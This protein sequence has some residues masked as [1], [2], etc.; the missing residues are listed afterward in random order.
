MATQL[1]Q[2]AQRHR[3]P[4]REIRTVVVCL[5]GET[6]P[7]SLAELAATKLRMR[8]LTPAGVIPH[9]PTATTW[10]TRKLVDSWQGLTSGGPIKLLDLAS[11]RR[12]A[13]LA[14]AAQWRLW[15]QVVDGTRPAQPFWAF[16]DRHAADPNRYP[17]EQAQAEYQAQPRILAMNTHNALPGT[18]CELPTA[19]VEAFQAGY[20]TYANLAWLAA[21]PADGV[22]TTHGVNSGWLT[23]AT[24]RL[25]DQLAY[26]Q[27]ANTYIDGLSHN[28]QLVAMAITA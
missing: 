12:N 13:H 14:A 19:T 3:W 10:R 11:M 15:H 7:R 26:L 1:A 6:E 22:A 21:V 17:L 8:K 24:G 27:A 9:F 28:E 5:P 18:V 4:T 23:C 25:A 2:P 20:G 16:L